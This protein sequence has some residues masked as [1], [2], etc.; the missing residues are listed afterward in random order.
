VPSW[1]FARLCHAF[2]IVYVLML[3]M[4]ADD[5]LVTAVIMFS[6]LLSRDS[7]CFMSHLRF[8]LSA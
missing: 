2:L 8:I 1:L 3:V 4:L 5:S 6:Q 7:K